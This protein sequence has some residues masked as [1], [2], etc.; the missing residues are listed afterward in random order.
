MGEYS[1]KKL[2]VLFFLITATR[3]NVHAQQDSVSDNMVLIKGGTFMM[4]SEANPHGRNRG[5]ENEYPRHQVSVNDFYMSKYEITQGQYFEVTGDNPSSNKNNPDDKTA[6]GWKKLPVES[7]SW[8]DTLVFCNRLSIREKLKPVY[9]VKG[10]VDPDDWGDNYKGRGT[11][12][13]DIKAN[14]YRLPTEAE[15]EY[16]CRAGTTTR[17]NTGDTITT[18]QANYSP[19][20][21]ELT[22]GLMTVG[23]FAPNAWGLYDMHGNVSEWCWDGGR[24][25]SSEPQND[26]VGASSW[27]VRGGNAFSRERDLRSANRN[28]VSNQLIGF[29]VVRNAQ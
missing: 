19:T 20:F 9:S 25:Y 15:W 13:M 23:S 29:R 8:F 5:N 21:R 28:Y 2:I 6:D 14:G 18:D 17:F 24:S 3:G 26:P 22:R 7:V 12:E 16:A 27:G 10:S 1:M 11:V 4:G